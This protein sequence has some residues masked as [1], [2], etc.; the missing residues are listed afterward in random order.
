MLNL[1]RRAVDYYYLF[2]RARLNHY[3]LRSIHHCARRGLN[4]F[5]SDAV[6]RRIQRFF[7]WSHS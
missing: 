6:Y 7:N 2:E 4:G 5:D 1:L 3:Y